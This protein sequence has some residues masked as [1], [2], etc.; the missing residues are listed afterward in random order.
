MI[1]VIDDPL[2]KVLNLQVL[3]P[4]ETFQMQVWLQG[5][6]LIRCRVRKFQANS[7]A[8]DEDELQTA[9]ADVAYQIRKVLCLLNE[10][11][12]RLPHR[13]GY[14]L[15]PHRCRTRNRQNSYHD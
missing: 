6:D 15:E 10:R 4:F 12:L 11:G 3:Q 8:N 9:W 1:D 2:P 14:L 13:I 5:F 7:R